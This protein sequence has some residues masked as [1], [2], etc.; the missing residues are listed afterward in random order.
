MNRRARLEADNE[1]A[2]QN[3]KRE[4]G[5]GKFKSYTEQYINSLGAFSDAIIGVL[6]AVAAQERI[7]SPSVRGPGW[8]VHARRAQGLDDP[9]RTSIFESCADCARGARRCGR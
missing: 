4:R 3:S 5:H 2:V 7:R 8:A 9:K 1:K 6:A